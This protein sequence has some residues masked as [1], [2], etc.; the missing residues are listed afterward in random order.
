MSHVID[1]YRDIALSQIHEFDGYYVFMRKD[2][3]MQLLFKPGFS[4][5]VENAKNMIF[6]FKKISPD[7]KVL[8][9][10][11]YQDDNTFT[12]ETRE[13]IAS[14]EVSETVAA[15]A[16]VIKGLALRIIGNGYLRINRP[17]RPTRIFNS[18]ESALKWL[19]QFLNDK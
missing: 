8:A 5:D 10:V 13:F 17:N 7:K 15:D 4:G 18:V 19:E 1:K 14:A 2:G 12:K 16:L 11:I 9:L 3:I 6:T